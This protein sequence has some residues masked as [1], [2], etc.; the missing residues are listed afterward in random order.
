MPASF[1]II[2]GQSQVAS[3]TETNIEITGGA[4]VITAIDRIRISQSTH[5]TSEQYQIF[6]QDVTTT[7][8]GDAYTPEQKEPGSQASAATVEIDSS[9]EPTYAGSTFHMNTNWN[10]LT[11]RDIVYPPG[12][13]IF[14]APSALMATY[15]VTPSG[16]TTF[17]PEHE[18]EI[19][20][21]G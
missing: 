13:E 2:A 19:T 17:V 6:L 18:V 8:T 15:I 12:R 14:I 9:V 20:E 16:T 3:A 7:G 11:G 10:S 5:T 21:T 4:A 1:V